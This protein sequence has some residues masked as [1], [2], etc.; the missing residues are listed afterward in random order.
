MCFIVFIVI[1]YWFFYLNLDVNFYYYFIILLC[2]VL[3]IFIV[4]FSK[5]YLILSIW[6]DLLGLSRFFLILYYNNWDSSSGSINTIIVG[7]FGDFFVFLFFSLFLFS[8]I[9]F[10]YYLFFWLFFYFVF[11]SFTK[12]GQ[13]PFSSWLPKAISAPTP[14]SSLVH[15]S[16]LVTSGLFIFYFFYLFFNFFFFYF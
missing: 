14:V 1:Y 13:F 15:R 8:Y 10:Y 3:R 9:S 7:R 11:F 5:N 16:T 2:F 12:S 6:W 4:V